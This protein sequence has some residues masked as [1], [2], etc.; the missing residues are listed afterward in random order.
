MSMSPLCS[1]PD[2]LLVECLGHLSLEE[3]C[4]AAGTGNPGSL[5]LPPWGRPPLPAAARCCPLHCLL[6]CPQA[7]VVTPPH[8]NMQAWVCGTGVK[9][10]V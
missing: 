7:N 8:A 9:A 2:S 3:R 10:L 5:A 6:Q 4:A 1:L